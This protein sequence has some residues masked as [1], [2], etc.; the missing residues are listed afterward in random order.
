MHGALLSARR[1]ASTSAGAMA[2]APL[3]RVVEELIDGQKYCP[4][5]SRNLPLSEYHKST[6]DGHC[7]RCRH[8]QNLKTKKR[9]AGDSRPPIADIVAGG[10][11]A[12][13]RC[14]AMKPLEEFNKNKQY[15]SGR[16]K[17][18]KCCSK[19]YY[20]ANRERIDA[21]QRARYQKNKGKLL[22][23]NR[24]GTYGLRPADYDRMFAE[25]SGVCAICRKVV[26]GNLCVDHNHETR[27]VRG[28]LCRKCN[29]GLG[30]FQDSPDLI[31]TAHAYLERH[32][33]QGAA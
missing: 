25:Q 21:R 2:D 19:E 13:R 33:R 28:L 20:H 18:C 16:Q 8:C 3:S 1:S 11:K 26:V 30:N 12:C 7:L 23:A 17:W 6:R 14:H 22:R 9:W 5:C 24:L 31:L 32:R 4:D 27:Q 10:K 15:R 29:T